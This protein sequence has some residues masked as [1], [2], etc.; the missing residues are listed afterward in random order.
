MAGGDPTPVF[1][2]RDVGLIIKS[3]PDQV[4]SQRRELLPCILR[5]WSC[6]DLREHLRMRG[7]ANSE[8]RRVMAVEKCARNLLQALDA[9]DEI[10][11][12]GIAGEMVIA[13]EKCA[14]NLLQALD[15]ADELIA[16]GSRVRWCWPPG[17]RR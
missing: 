14:R 2:D 7:G 6:V 12:A 16:R 4:D 3:L 15:A 5:E 11:R 17:T 8:R 1:T 9:A 10:D 13:V